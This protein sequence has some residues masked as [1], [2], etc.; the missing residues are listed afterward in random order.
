MSAESAAPAYL[1]IKAQIDQA[2]VRGQRADRA[3]P[4]ERAL[5]QEFGVTRATVRRAVGQLVDEGRLYSVRGAGTY[6][7]GPGIAKTL[8][9]NSFTEEVRME[10]HEPSSHL[11][12]V[13]EVPAS[14]H[15]ARRLGLS[16]GAPVIEIRR[17]RCSDGEPMCLESAS[18]PCGR[19]PQLRNHDLTGSLYRLLADVYGLD[20]SWAEQQVEAVVY[21]PDEAELLGVAPFSAALRVERTTFDARG[22]RAEFCVTSYRADKFSLRFSVRR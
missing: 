19:V 6:C 10:G 16:P 12:G 2:Y 17:L 1:R 11:L 3:I 5:A 22:G 9:L 18:L 4:A 14:E 21:A 13:A 7:V 15:V 20:L 8:R